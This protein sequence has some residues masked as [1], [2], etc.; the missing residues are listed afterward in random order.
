MAEVS[1]LDITPDPKVLLALT[2]TPL[3]PVDALCEL[4]DNGIDAFSAARNEG[5]PIAHQIIEVL[6][7]TA[8]AIKRGEGSIRVFDRGAGLDRA[9]LENTLRAGFSGKNRFDTLGLFGMGFNIATGK[10][11]RRTVVTTARVADNY[12]LRVTLDLP[13]IVSSRSFNVPVETIPKPPN[14][15]HGTI[16]EVDR[17]WPEGDANHGF[18][19]QL[20]SANRANIRQQL[21]RRYA[22]ILRSNEQ[23]TIRIILNSDALRAFEHCIWSA[24]RFVERRGWG[25]IPARYDFNE[26]IYSQKRCIA[27]GSIVPAEA[28]ACLECGAQEFRTV[29]ERIRGWV[30]IQR[31]D[32]NNKFGIDLVRNGRTIR[33]AEK[34]AFFSYVDSVGETVKEYPTDQQTGRI[35]GE[36]HLDH[37]PVDFQKQDFQRTTEEWT[38]AIAYLR[39]GSLLPS[40]WDS[41]QENVSPVSKLFQGFRKVR[42]PGPADAYMGR[43]D[44]ATGK[45]V[46][47]SR[48]TEEEYYAKFLAHEEGYYDDKK[49]WDLVESA[50]TP[51]VLHLPE[52]QACGYQNLPTAEV[53]EGCDVLLRAKRCIA[54]GVDIPISAL[55]CPSCAESQV[56]EVLDPWRCQ[57]CGATNDTDSESCTVCGYTHGTPDPM[58]LDSL[59]T[60]STLR[61]SYSFASRVFEMSDGRQT[62][63]LTVIGYQAP[64]LRPTWSGDAVPTVAFRSPGKIQIFVHDGHPAFNH[65]GV[66]PQD[67]IATEAAH[68]LWSLRSDLT[69]RRGHSVPTIAA[70]IVDSVWSDEFSV[71]PDSTVEG[72]RALLERINEKLQFMEDIGDFYSELDEYEQRTLA[73]RLISAGRLGELGELISTGGYIRFA[74]PTVLA[75][76]FKRQ[77]DLWFGTIWDE[78]LPTESAVGAAAAATVREQRVGIYLRC[79]EDCA[80]YARFVYSDPLVVAHAE[81]S[82]DFLEAHVL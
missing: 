55:S 63:P 27:D 26:S 6:L 70:K 72:I 67:L 35:V 22:S 1:E 13:S 34:D 43:W 81:A 5:N 58:S 25:N 17:W 59:I 78:V 54:C 52:C 39:G 49:W 32:D 74:G 51:P 12:A 15:E 2:Q 64:E 68:Y 16:V 11:G 47:I 10:L 61:D 14:F 69:G 80:A 62:E 53:C 3:R 56:P 66:R 50:S 82:R 20:A 30:G 37:I 57:V 24:E 28:A 21:G 42:T 60:S 41:L 8:A 45:P 33:V 40:N 65:L 77:S 18:A 9:G 4:I 19:A 29:E 48:Q 79:L 36:V 38:R 23:N 44:D 76:H 46:R 75:K 71:T 31:F 73:D 7:P